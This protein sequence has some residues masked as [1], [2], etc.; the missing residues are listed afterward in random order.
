MRGT[1]TSFATQATAMACSGHVRVRV[2]RLLGVLWWLAVGSL[3]V[4]GTSSA[5]LTHEF[6]SSFGSFS[7]VA[8]IAADSSS[9]DVYVFDGG[10]GNGS[11]FKFTAAGAPAEFSSTKAD[12]VEGVGSA[13]E[14]EG[15][16]A[17]D[18]S[19]S[20]PAKGDIY[21]AN[22]SVVKIFAPSGEPLGELTEEPGKPWGK[23]CGVAVDTAGHVSVAL[24]AT[25]ADPS[26]TVN[27]YAPAANPV[28]NGDYTSSL[29]KVNNVCD[30]AVDGAGNLYADTF[31]EGPVTRFEALQFSAVEVEATGIVIAEPGQAVAVDTANDPVAK[32]ENEIYVA[33]SGEVAQYEPAGGLVGGFASDATNSFG[34]VRGVAVN[35]VS[36]RVY[37]SDNQNGRVDV[38]G[39]TVV[40]PDVTTETA[41]DLTTSSAVLH[42]TVN[43][44]E[45][46]VSGCRFEYGTT[47]AYGQSAGCEP[48]PGS[49]NSPVGVTATIGGLAPNTTYHYR[50]V[51][52]NPN[53]TNNGADQTL[54]TLSP[55]LIE[56][57]EP[58]D[59]LVTVATVSARVDPVGFATTY[60]FEYGPGTSY[61]AS[62]PV[63]D[64]SIG[65]GTGYVTVTE[66]L[67]GLQPAS[68]YHYR[69]IASSANGTTVGPDQSLATMPA[70]PPPGS[71]HCTNEA[72]RTG[73]SATLPDCRAYEQLTPT[74]KSSA[75][76][77]MD[78]SSTF[79]SPSV[80]GERLALLTLVTL[81]PEPQ[82][83]GSF[84][85]FTRTPAGWGLASVKPSGSGSTVYGH[86][87]LDPELSHVGVDATTQYPRSTD[88]T[89][90]VGVA[91][92]P[93][94]AVAAT[95]SE[96][97]HGV[98][99]DELLGAS[100]DYSHVIFGSVDHALLPGE[101]TGTNEK[102]FDLYEW[103]GG[104]ECGQPGSSCR[105]VNVTGEG[106]QAKVIGKCGAT[107]GDGELFSATMGGHGLA[108]NAV[109][110]DGSKIFFT[111]PDPQ[112]G[113]EEG[114]FAP[115][116]ETSVGLNPPQLY[117]RVSETVEGSE[118]SRTVE[119][120]APESP[121]VHLSLR[122][123]EMAAYYQ[124][125]TADGSK[126][127]SS[128]REH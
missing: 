90:Q 32:S 4:C 51:A 37:V 96:D 16:V 5:A 3:C 93:F 58:S 38:F 45:V 118:R 122:E 86:Q 22:G 64:G 28:V 46:P 92:G 7:G 52:S 111:A 75:V 21:V 50:L 89:F 57:Q 59:V 19:A 114:C 115:G 78:V 66:Q 91:G 76:Q 24:A 20:G 100:R 113:G 40:V 68:I 41:T 102:A 2:A 35:P 73:P 88:N 42:G 83:G 107:L 55:P 33:R 123:E 48:N 13:G 8:G 53:G 125:A 82:L 69:V 95:P 121:E 39:P 105:L 81:G 65:S 85:V 26:S 56:S 87:I 44:A 119:L 23:P 128:Q 9:G 126:V 63:P 36:G 31:P 30:L 15:Q 109:S 84:S 71:E 77:D 99:G 18:D 27:Q 127:S 112:G 108:H 103:A 1:N 97:H 34:N 98:G 25:G 14:G 124:A 116:P 11:L 94:A 117:M 74:D 104:A 67:T 120:S 17:V 43:P 6:A 79:S 101:P 110:D 54:T 12:V 60:R 106:A 80:D 61:G 72:A 47:E 49:G 29:W 70:A 62:V 10:A